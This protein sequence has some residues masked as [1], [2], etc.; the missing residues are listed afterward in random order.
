MLLRVYI[1]DVRALAVK[2]T[3]KHIKST[4]SRRAAHERGSDG[5]GD[6]SSGLA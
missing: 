4:V 1:H 2:L 5:A 6:A 3:R